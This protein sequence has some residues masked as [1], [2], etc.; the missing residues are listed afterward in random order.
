MCFTFAK[1]I[2]THYYEKDCF[3]DFR[4]TYY[5]HNFGAKSRVDEVAG[6]KKQV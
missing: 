3:I 6:I 5:H 1:K 4:I 2:K